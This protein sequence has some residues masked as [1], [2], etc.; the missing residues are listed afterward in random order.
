MFVASVKHDSAKNRPGS[1]MTVSP[2]SFP[3]YDFKAAFTA[4]RICARIRGPTSDVEGYADNGEPRGLSSLEERRDFFGK[5]AVLGTQRAARST[6]IR[7]FDPNQQITFR[8]P[9]S[10]LLDL[11]LRIESCQVHANARRVPDVRLD[12]TRVSEDDPIRRNPKC[13]NGLNLGPT[14]AVKAGTE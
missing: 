4:G 7:S 11:V 14:C 8:V 3:K 10:N 2:D 1:A 9:L 12:F 6:I 13:E 5:R